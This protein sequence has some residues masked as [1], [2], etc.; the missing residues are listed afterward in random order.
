MIIPK[1]PQ[2]Y[3][4]AI[5]ILGFGALV[6]T[7]TLSAMF[8][9]TISPIMI[10]ILAIISLASGLLLVVALFFYRIG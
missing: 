7:L 5:A 10:P 1:G 8:G 6:A 3:F 9:F 2:A 4:R